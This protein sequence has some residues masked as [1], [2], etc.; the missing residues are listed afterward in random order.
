MQILIAAKIA[1]EVEQ[2]NDDWNPV[3]LYRIR[4]KED[5]AALK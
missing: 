1:A 4:I 2:L 5:Q 3:E